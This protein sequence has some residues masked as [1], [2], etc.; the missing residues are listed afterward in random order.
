LKAVGEMRDER[1]RYV[2]FRFDAETPIPDIEE[3][4]KSLKSTAPGR[5]ARLIFYDPE[6]GRGILRCPHT[7]LEGIK[8]LD[9]RAIGPGLRIRI[10]GVS[11]TI[12]RVRRKF[13]SEGGRALR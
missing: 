3:L 13:L 8:S 2:V 12:K 6:T 9:G 1:R 7:A 11:G 5:F 4:I 10:I